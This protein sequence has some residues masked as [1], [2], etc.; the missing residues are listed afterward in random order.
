MARA[1]G[2]VILLGEH[3]VVYGVPAIAAG[4]GKGATA[5]AVPAERPLLVLGAERVVRAGEDDELGRAF[6]ALHA[7]TGVGS[8]RIDVT[9][10]LP[11]GAG[12]GASASIGVATARALFEASGIEAGRERVL[13]AAGAWERVFHGNPS[14]IDA[15]AAACEAC[16]LYSRADGA[17]PIAVAGEVPLVIG[18]AG[19]SA[20]TR[21]M[22]EGVAELRQRKPEVVDKA[23][24]G[25]LALVNAAKGCLGVGDLRGLGR[26]MDLNQM[27]LS[28]LFVS[29][30]GIE[31]ACA[32][33][34]AAGAL[35]AK[36]TG[37]G[38]GGAVIALAPGDPEVILS[39]FR[40]EGIQC[41]ATTV[42][43]S[44]GGTRR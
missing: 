39:A 25:I 6:T 33:A 36:L 42:G 27:L 34:R 41:F 28:G 37:S 43:A 22:V 32:V 15:E 4:I 26:L 9:L 35:G 3:A 23:M 11:P 38:G 16:I 5:I 30:E 31:R 8:Y 14:G 7:A 44:S 40:S 18:I 12:L 20:S 10:E 29:T 19:P 1:N 21:V 2:K 24:A 17:R 13:E